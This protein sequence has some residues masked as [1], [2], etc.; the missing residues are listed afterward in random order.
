[1][2]NDDCHFG[3][4]DM[5]EAGAYLL[6]VG[7]TEDDVRGGKIL[8][9]SVKKAMRAKN[10]DNI[11]AHFKKVK[12]SLK[13]ELFL[14]E[15]LQAVV[16]TV[17]P[18]DNATLETTLERFSQVEEYL[19]GKLG[20]RWQLEWNF[21][22]GSNDGSEDERKTS[23]SKRS[24]RTKIAPQKG[25]SRHIVEPLRLTLRSGIVH[26][27]NEDNE[28]L[29]LKFPRELKRNFFLACADATSGFVEL[30]IY[31]ETAGSDAVITAAKPVKSNDGG[32][33]FD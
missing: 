24:A 20:N 13:P 32:F 18:L 19:D 16:L 29:S 31:T 7:T 33:D 14:S 10:W 9:E 27:A 17:L 26:V 21:N 25:H 11:E 12:Y 30:E 22:S 15:V 28:E 8:T 23:N 4:G 1:M 6:C 3:P 2:K 5:V